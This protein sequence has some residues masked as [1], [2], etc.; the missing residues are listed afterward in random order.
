MSY[1]IGIDLGTT[2]SAL[3]AVDLDLTEGDEIALSVLEVPQS[4][5]PGQ[6]ESKALLPSFLYLPHGASGELAG[7]SLTLPWDAAP[8]FAVGE[9]ARVL[10]Q[11][12][13]LRLVS[14]AKS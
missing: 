5:S 8:P 6:V 3:A 4:T 7:G 14:S 9:L 12:T 1:A 2:H 13:P 11:K 10:G